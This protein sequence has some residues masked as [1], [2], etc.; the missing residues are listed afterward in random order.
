M[1]YNPNKVTASKIGSLN[2]LFVAEQVQG[3]RNPVIGLGCYSN[4]ANSA[5]E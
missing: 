3:A 5:H 1:E 2:K 4:T